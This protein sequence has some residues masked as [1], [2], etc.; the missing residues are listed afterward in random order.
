MRK[1]LLLLLLAGGQQVLAAPAGDALLEMQRDWA[2]ANY[3]Q[4]GDSQIAAFEQL[5]EKSAQATRAYPDSAGIWIWDGIIRSS[6]AGVRGG[7]GALSLA[8][9]S[10][11]SLE[12][13]MELDAGALDGS[14]YTSLGTL[15]FKVPGW[16]VG[17]G[18][19]RKAAKFLQQALI[20]N[21]DGIDPNYFYADYLMSRKDFDA[22]EQ[23]L[24]KAQQAAPRAG[25]ERADD[26]RQVEIREALAVVRKKLGHASS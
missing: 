26:G 2:V 24:L 7:L 8:K 5:A 11:A 22:A 13:A 15:Y 1:I 20:I 10:R 16:P 12:K 9:K 25:R 21:P 4:T 14:A 23:Y 18:S 17:F 6:F 3:D 19:D